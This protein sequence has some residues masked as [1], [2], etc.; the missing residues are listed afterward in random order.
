MATR[1]KISHDQIQRATRARANLSAGRVVLTALDGEDERPVREWLYDD[2]REAGASGK[3]SHAFCEDV[4]AT[5][6]EH[7][8]AMGNGAHRYA[9]RTS[10]ALGS[11]KANTWFRVVVR[12]SREGTNA[13]D[14]LD[15]SAAAFMTHL[16]RAFEEERKGR[17]DAL[18]MVEATQSGV[19]K[20]L[21][22]MAERQ[23]ILEVEHRATR[24]EER[25]QLTEALALLEAASQK[26]READA[27]GGGGDFGAMMQTV[28]A[29]LAEKALERFAPQ[30][31]PLVN[32]LV[33]GMMQG[34]EDAA[35]ETVVD[36]VA[37][38]RL[39]S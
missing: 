7:A 12:E 32:Q 26:E 3:A 23:T 35:A 6:L 37:P 9:L 22:A 15:G 29:T 33:K 13:M 16:Q 10:D 21:S 20:L 4:T 17:H 25:K 39:D 24:E 14:E 1:N 18:R 31:E 11:E 36:V 30:L 38:P 2:T 34:G 8:E 27:G 19:L 28:G 5:V